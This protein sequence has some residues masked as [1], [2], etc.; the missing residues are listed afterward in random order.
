MASEHQVLPM[1][2]VH[3]VGRLHCITPLTPL[4][5][6]EFSSPAGHDTVNTSTVSVQE[7][8][9]DPIAPVLPAPH[10]GA[11]TYAA[12]SASPEV[13]AELE[14]MVGNVSD[15]QATRLFI[16]INSYLH[17]ASFITKA[18]NVMVDFLVK[19]RTL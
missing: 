17:D 18:C 5:T 6:A 3:V 16:L 8:T 2:A 13:L 12:L 14:Q 7:K 10:L 1:Y 15:Q 4:D 19:S 11:A 9:T